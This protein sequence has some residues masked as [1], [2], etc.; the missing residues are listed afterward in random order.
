MIRQTNY[1]R[2]VRPFILLSIL[3]SMLLTLL[4]LAA[5]DSG[6]NI[7]SAEKPTL[8]VKISSPADSKYNTETPTSTTY[9]IPA[10]VGSANDATDGE[11]SGDQLVWTYTNVASGIEYHF[12]D[13]PIGSSL[14]IKATGPGVPPAPRISKEFA[15]GKY[16]VHLTATNSKDE[17]NTAHKEIFINR[18]PIS[19]N[20]ISPKS[21]EIIQYKSNPI[22]FI[23]NVYDPEDK[24]LTGK[25]IQWHIKKINP[26]GQDTDLLL[27]AT[28]ENTTFPI[29]PGLYDLWLLAKDSEDAVIGNQIRFSVVDESGGN[30]RPV[31]QIALPKPG[32]YTVGSTIVFEGSATDNEDGSLT[33]TSLVWSSNI[34]GL[35]GYGNSR[36]C[37]SNDPTPCEKSLSPGSHTITLEATDSGLLSA[38]ATVNI[39][40]SKQ[41]GDTDLPPKNLTKALFIDIAPNLPKGGLLPNSVSLAIA[42]SDAVTPSQSTGLSGYYIKVLKNGN[43]PTAPDPLGA[44]W[45]SIANNTANY[46]NTI[47]YALA[48]NTYLPGSTLDFYVWFKDTGN[49]LSAYATDSISYVDVVSPVN[50]MTAPGFINE[51]SPPGTP[52]YSK[53]VYLSLNAT[54]LWGVSAFYVYE[55]NTPIPPVATDPNWINIAETTNYKSATPYSLKGNYING[56]IISLTVW[57]KDA[58]N[59]ISVASTTDTITYNT[60]IAN[61]DFNSGIPINWFANNGGDWSFVNNA[62]PCKTPNQSACVATSLGNYNFVVSDLISDT[63]NLPN[64]LPSQRIVLTGTHWHD[65]YTKTTRTGMRVTTINDYANLDIS[66]DGGSTWQT[67]QSFSQASSS[68]QNNWVTLSQP[69]AAFAG[70]SVKLRFRLQPDQSNLGSGT[71]NYLGWYLKYFSI[72]VQ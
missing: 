9:T 37:S 3:S 35:L 70:K 14:A 46:S 21:G 5:C 31:V 69:L 28:G 68:A 12:D 23:A 64:I 16:I 32:D 22:R 54:D 56:D 13:T 60:S 67:L 39:S 41:P 72:Q 24:T 42:A 61:E 29:E 33:G 6:S 15:A 65:L 62:N 51:S 8:V 10:F 50:N 38:L 55:G 2:S 40:V 20:I 66:T 34:D 47:N 71:A 63:Y 25:N 58:N 48:N 17:T 1:H 53:T 59:N 7:S 43:I 52:A 57:F 49:Q 44:G 18:M 36:T 4:V 30:T 26:T 27:F 45:V 11:I 19:A